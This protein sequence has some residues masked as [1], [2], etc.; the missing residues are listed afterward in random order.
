MFYRVHT[1]GT[2]SEVGLESVFGGP[3]GTTCWIIGGGPSLAG[4][5]CDAISASPS[6]KFAVNLA[7]TSLLRPNFWTSYDPSARFHRSVYLDGSIMKFLHERR[8]MDLVPETT[9]KVCEC[10]GT[11]FFERDA[12]RGFADFLVGSQRGVID[13]NDSLLQAIDIAYRLG[14]RTLYLAGCDLHVKPSPDQIAH[15]SQVGVEYERLETL[16]SFFRRCEEA[17]CPREEFSRMNAPLQYHFDERKA[18]AAAVQTDLHYFRV[19]QYLRLARRSLSLTGLEIVSVTPGSRLNDHFPFR[20]VETAA[21]EI[22]EAVGDPDSETTRGRY[23]LTKARA[24]SG[25]GPMRDV[26]PHHWKRRG[27]RRVRKSVPIENRDAPEVTKDEAKRAGDGKGW[28]DVPE[29]CVDL[30]EDG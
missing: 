8:A 19:V 3:I 22:L 20:G 26:P 24:P 18:L 16:D 7:G 10:P 12:D 29:V 25:I 21:A 14:F 1:D 17:G 11:V 4:V 5:P 13:W 6:V 2:R 30:D 28:D 27:E 15:A 23:S 9:F